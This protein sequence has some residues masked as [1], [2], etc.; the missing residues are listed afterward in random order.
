MII[1]FF[2]DFKADYEE[3]SLIARNACSGMLKYYGEIPSGGNHKSTMIPLK[4]TL[5]N[6]MSYH[7][8]VPT[9]S[10]E[11]I[12][13]ACISG[14]NG[15]GKSALIDAM[16]WAL[17]GKTRANS[18]DDLIHTGQNEME[19]DFEFAI[20][21]Q[22]YLIVRKHAKPKNS[23]GSGQTIIEFQSITEEGNKV[24]TGDTASQ[25]Q[26][27]ITRALHMDYETFIN[28]A[29][30]RQ[31][32]ADE[33]TKKRPAERKQVL[34]NILQLSVYD[35]L[36]TQANELSKRQ[37][38]QTDQLE[39]LLNSLQEELANKP[40][41][42]AE[43]AAA[44]QKF[45]EIEK[46]V[47]IQKSVEE[48]L[49]LD[50][51]ILESKRSQLAEI[52]SGL[53]SLENN[54]KLWSEQAK[55]NQK[56]VDAF[57]KLIDQKES[58]E[59]NFNK[60]M[61]IRKQ[62]QEYEQKSKLYNVLIQNRHRLELTINKAAEE[63]NKTHA[64]SDN[65]ILE[66]EKTAAA[67]PNLQERLKEI[68]L[69]MTGLDKG[70]IIIQVQRD[71]L[72]NLLSQT[73]LLHSEISRVQVDLHDI[74]EKLELLAHKEDAAC[75]LCE[76]ELGIEGKHKI[77]SK[78]LAEKEAKQH[79][80]EIHQKDIKVLESEANQV[81]KDL[82]ADESKLK[83]SRSKLQNQLGNLQKAISDA[84][85][86]VTQCEKERE[87]LSE[88]ENKLASRYFARDEE[89]LLSK[90]D[91]E[92]YNL[93]YDSQKYE[94][95]RLELSEAE[96]Y[97]EPK[98]QLEEATGSISEA[99]ENLAIALNSA[100]ACED[101]LKA[102]RARR[103]TLKSELFSYIQVAKSLQ[104]AE[105]EHQRILIQQRQIQQEVGTTQAKLD[106]LN[107]VEKACQEKLSQINELKQ[108]AK[109]FK[110]LA[111]AFGKKGIQAMLIETA[112]PEI[113]NEAN[114]LLSR[115]T[116]NQMSVKLETQRETKKGDVQE[117][118][119]I[120]ISD[121]LGTRNYEMF[122]GGEAFRIDFAVRIALSKL[123]ARR[124]GAPLPTLI[125]DEGFGT[126]D[127]TGIEKIKEAITSIQDDFQKILVITHISDFKDAF[128]VRLEIVKTPEGS[129]VYL[130]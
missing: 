99:Q 34:A 69:E 70:E 4:L 113:E 26:T 14:N 44:K 25:T 27:I 115:M 60:L 39:I 96:K 71:R 54:F 105:I 82:L 6:F 35:E 117:T 130:N 83:I 107:T 88:I 104:L 15:N 118:L 13:T 30:L 120:N 24:L 78:Y 36:E 11:S 52:E 46:M 76:S 84:Q 98:R 66:L 77:E 59:V 2:D 42:E 109:I 123:L 5:H 101:K 80:L 64:V 128:P 116:D 43:Y 10:F 75:P 31:G 79:K 94:S 28:S 81:S 111:Q 106:R 49:R 51:Q 114:L 16:T 124:A 33:F 72:Q 23:K 20:E 110:D 108:Q 1:P 93:Q 67:L 97:A 9:I 55:Q 53:P 19:V 119:D 121:E 68:N 38:S 91:G 122:S 58:I 127:S 48:N 29:F 50:K 92:I 18:D 22:R 65:R 129:S 32:R 102:D 3:I 73:S 12:H 45:I 37:S 95:V 125:I 61:L 86:A 41:Y 112:I 100:K 87:T 62:I 47:E 21:K 90:L 126:Q 57:Q 8:N 7:D 56:R 74:T 40:L 17:W 63:L 85:M 103:E 89:L